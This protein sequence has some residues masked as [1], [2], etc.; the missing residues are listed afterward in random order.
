MMSIGQ[1]LV[2]VLLLVLV[3]AVLAHR[4]HSAP[5]DGARNNEP[6]IGENGLNATLYWA[7]ATV[8]VVSPVVGF[9]VASELNI[10]PRG[11]GVF[12]VIGLLVLLS[13]PATLMMARSLGPRRY[14]SYWQHLEGRSKMN[15]KRIVKL[16]LVLCV[17]AFS[18][19]IVDLMRGSA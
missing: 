12:S 16:W 15:R 9:V 11:P 2:F 10:Q 4:A 13:L 5:K 19:G 1:V 3:R 6:A 7:M 17:L 8:I 18:L 14:E